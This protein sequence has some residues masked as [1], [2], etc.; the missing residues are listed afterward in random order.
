MRLLL[1]LL[2]CPGLASA[3]ESMELGP[4]AVPL[5]DTELSMVTSSDQ[6]WEGKDARTGWT[7]RVESVGDGRMQTYPEPLQV[8]DTVAR[9]DKLLEPTDVAIVPMAG[10]LGSLFGARTRAESVRSCFLGRGGS[11][12]IVTMRSSRSM[13]ERSELA[14]RRACKDATFAGTTELPSSSLIGI[15]FDAKVPVDWQPMD[16]PGPRSRAAAFNQSATGLSGIVTWQPRE[17]HPFDTPDLGEVQREL[18]RQ[19]YRVRVAEVMRVAG[20]DAPRVEVG[21][22]G[23]GGSEADWLLAIVRGERSIWMIQSPTRSMG[24]PALKSLFDLA[25]ARATLTED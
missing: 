11:L 2:L 10:R 12:W 15:T 14:L 16:P 1:L 22:P 8:R 6:H 18:S 7:W 21:Q 3:A 4:L 19:G 5:P 20:Q 23:P 13:I 25:L 17:G 9:R 24:Y